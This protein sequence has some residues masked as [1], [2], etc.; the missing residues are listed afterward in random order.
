MTPEFRQPN[1]KKIVTECFIE[2]FGRVPY[3]ACSKSELDE[4]RKYYGED[5]YD[6]LGSGNIIYSDGVKS[7][8]EYS[9][10]FFKLKN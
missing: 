7:E 4:A 6:Y 1:Q 5:N 2:G 3:D 9:Y 8:F 10:H